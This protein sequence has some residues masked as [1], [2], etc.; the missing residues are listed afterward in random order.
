MILYEKT[1]FQVKASILKRKILTFL[2]LI[3][4]LIV[5]PFK[6]IIFKI[7]ETFENVYHKLYP[8][9]HKIDKR[10]RLA[11]LIY[12][13]TAILIN[14]GF[15]IYFYV[16]NIDKIL[17]NTKILIAI[18]I[19]YFIYLGLKLLLK[20]YHFFIGEYQAL[21]LDYQST[22]EYV[23]TKMPKLQK[24]FGYTGAGKDTYMA[25]CSSILVKDFRQRTLN[26]MANIR[27]ICYIFDFDELDQDLLNNSEYFLSFSHE[28]I[29]KSYLGDKSNPG[30]AMHKNLYIKKYYLKQGIN[31]TFLINDYESFEA[32]I[33]NSDSPYTYGTGVCRKHFLEIVMLEYI[34]WFVRIN[35]EKNYLM[36]NQPFVENLETG[37]MAKQFSFNFLKTRV[38]EKKIRDKESGKMITLRENIFFPWKDRLILTE[39]ECGSWYS[40]KD[41][42]VYNE[43]IS[44]GAR[45]FKAQQR[46]FIIDF[47]WFQVD[48]TADRTAKLFRELDHAYACI[49]NREVV[50]GG[51]KRNAII[52]LQLM[53]YTWRLNRIS[54]INSK[55]E[56]KL[57]NKYQKLEDLKEMYL[58]SSN[59]KYRLKYNKIQNKYRSLK[60]LNK[61]EKYND[62]ISKLKQAYNNNQQDGYIIETVCISR[63]GAEPVDYTIVP[64]SKILELKHKNITYVTQLI[65]KISDCQRYDTRYMRNLAEERA[66]NSKV[67]F[68]DIPTWPTNLKMSQKEVEWMC[69]TTANKMYGISE[70]TLDD[71]KFNDGYKEY[72]E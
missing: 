1:L 44:T 3:L 50:P 65:F 32:D 60:R 63:T 10:C 56:F 59:E 34:E 36:T 52:E 18:P 4:R 45:D 30:M 14:L 7:V 22:V 8:I 26:D 49:L 54:L 43:I 68:N 29:K 28:K 61:I 31:S 53:Y 5:A 55:N 41:E 48:Q 71:I 67:T 21:E 25:G 51:K 69:Y 64:I 35:I 15:Y 2:K 20:V 58:A 40:N 13:C 46:H 16:K 38:I 17:F 24:I 57:M 72:L 19:I 62:I 66:Y 70:S 37:L 27:D 33:I 12:S 11:I 6:W 9:R 23:C 47:Y 39:T 42:S